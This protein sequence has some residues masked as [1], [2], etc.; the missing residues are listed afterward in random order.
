M[1]IWYWKNGMN[2]A[3]NEQLRNCD[4]KTLG[5]FILSV[6]MSLL[7]Q[8]R[9]VLINEKENNC[10]IIDIANPADGKVHEKEEEI[11]RIWKLKTVH[12]V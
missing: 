11:G 2:I 6:K 8:A 5:G 12:I 10:A 1:K 7:N 4:V 3:Q 9:I